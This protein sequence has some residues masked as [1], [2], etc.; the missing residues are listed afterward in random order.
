MK[1]FAALEKNKSCAEYT[2]LHRFYLTF[3]N[4]ELE[5]SNLINIKVKPFCNKDPS[6][7]PLRILFLELPYRLQTCH[8]GF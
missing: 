5:F 4:I 6:L 7:R 3:L 2:L 8:D 1:Y